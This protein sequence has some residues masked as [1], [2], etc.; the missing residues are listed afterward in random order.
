MSSNDV[1]IPV[2]GV[3]A[4][5]LCKWGWQV[6]KWVFRRLV[7]EP[8]T[9][10]AELRVKTV[11]GTENGRGPLYPM[12]ERCLHLQEAQTEDLERIKGQLSKTSGRLDNLETTVTILARGQ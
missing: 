2:F 6:A 8:V 7:A 11:V 3:I 4:L 1:L 5:A 12:V 10:W 9:E